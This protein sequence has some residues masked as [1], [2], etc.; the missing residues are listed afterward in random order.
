MEVESEAEAEVDAE[1]AGDVDVASLAAGGGVVAATPAVE[2]DALADD[3]TAL[4]LPVG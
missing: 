3:G 1:A 2:A 4:A